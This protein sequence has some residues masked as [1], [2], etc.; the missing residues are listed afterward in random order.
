MKIIRNY[1]LF[2]I[3]NI[4]FAILLKSLFCIILL[5]KTN[6][7]IFYVFF[8]IHNLKYISF[9][10]ISTNFIYSSAIIFYLS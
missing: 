8:Y 7:Q 5:I 9:P 2:Q 1:L 6:F 10:M 4:R 3:I